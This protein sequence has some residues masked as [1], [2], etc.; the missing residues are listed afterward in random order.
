MT[1][2]LVRTRATRAVGRTFGSGSIAVFLAA[3]VLTEPQAALAEQPAST[4]PAKPAAQGALGVKLSLGQSGFDASTVRSAIAQELGVAVV[5]ADDDP[6]SSVWL[7]VRVETADRASV[8][9]RSSDG[10]SVGRSIELPAQRERALETIALLASNVARNEAA[11]L[12]EALERRAAVARASGET[13][14]SATRPGPAA[15]PAPVEPAPR[16][17]AK[18]PASAP[19]SANKPLLAEEPGVN[20]SL[21]HPIAIL[22]DSDRRRLHV[23][24]GLGYSRAGAIEGMAVNALFARLDQQL[25]GMLVAGLGGW[26]GGDSQGMITGGLGVLSQ[27]RLRGAA[28][29]GLLSLHLGRG[30]GP[31]GT[32]AWAG[33]SLEGIQSAGLW[34]HAAGDLVGVQAAG[35]MSTL[36]GN[37]TGMQ[38]AGALNWTQGDVEGFQ[39]AAVNIARGS[40]TGFVAGVVNLSGLGG[41]SLSSRG[42]EAGVVNID[43]ASSKG[44]QVGVVN[45]SGPQT[46]AQIGVV[47][48]SDELDGVPIGLVNLGGNTHTSMVAFTT[49]RTP[50]NL[51][52]K[53]LTG[54]TFS[55]LSAGYDPRGTSQGNAH[56]VLQSA[57]QF[58]GH[59]PFAGRGAIE[60]SVGYA[61]ETYL[62]ELDASVGAGH[63]ALYRAALG[64]HFIPELGVF[65]GGGLR[66]M[67]SHQGDVTYE[68]E[69][70]GGVEAF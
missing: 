1:E 53:F 33:A 59:I 23:E 66:Q 8:N 10:R 29:G 5:D 15:P 50:A 42:F 36:A 17:Q 9:Y 67:I 12:I 35:G 30:S 58:G 44:L 7:E 4:A 20:L 57:I 32:D 26:A 56:E 69:G 25:E 47:N 68:A 24:L 70:F 14:P 39:A 43:R 28:F 16:P 60:P 3:A 21:W 27:G 19:S 13:S 52:V 55:M 2:E 49:N 6:A 46:G 18:P 54:Y 40:T 34:S 41:P 45:I 64:W 11:E 37:L 63:V 48:I 31:Y 51:G 38:A 62:S 65:A 61:Y 22:P